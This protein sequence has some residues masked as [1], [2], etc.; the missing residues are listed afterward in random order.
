MT[1]HVRSNLLLFGLSIAI[2]CVAYPLVLLALGW[3]LF[4][5]NAEGSLVRVKGSDG[6]ERV[7]GSRLIAQPFTA[8]EYFWPRPSAASYNGAAA[9]G[10]NWG[11]NQPKLRDRAA[12]Q[13]GGMVV[14]RAG[15]KS[16]GPD[17]SKARTPQEDIAAWAAAKPDR[18]ADWANE[19]G[20]TATGW[21]RTDVT[22]DEKGDDKYG[23]Q[24]EYV[25][26]WAKDHPEAAEDWKKSNPG[27]EPKPED[28]VG[29]FFIDFA[30]AHP[31][32][33]PGVVE[34]KEGDKVTKSIEVVDPDSAVAPF[35]FDM[36]LQ[37]AANAAKVA[38]LEPVPA[39]MVTASGSGL[40][41]H[42]TVRNAQSVYQLDRVAAARAGKRDVATVR[43]EIAR[44][45]EQQPFTPLGGSAGE[46]L[47]NVLELNVAL[48]AQFPMPPAEG[49]GNA[50]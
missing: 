29:A 49:G 45:V 5:S 19:N 33:W 39:D 42:I 4:P 6:T 18:A 25:A 9:G 40:D 17:A 47:V 34:K 38:D 15:S 24:G 1:K 2:C 8:N 27:K 12:Q 14:Y 28:L 32:K 31:G 22:K 16:A 36:W 13:L 30:R 50:R 3:T 41:P 20:V 35:F 10:S 26:A 43:K 23:L 46:P 7:V 37:D 21:A 48:D 11:A 44:L